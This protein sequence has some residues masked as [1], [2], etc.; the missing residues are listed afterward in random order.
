MVDGPA[1]LDAARL[2]DL[3]ASMLPGHLGIRIASVSDGAVEAALEVRSI[4]LAPN[5]FLHAAAVVAL[6]DTATG[7]GCARSLPERAIGFTTA[8]LKAN[9]LGTATE[10]ELWCTASLLHGGRTTQVWDA[11]VTGDSARTLAVFRCTQ[12]ILW[13]ST[14]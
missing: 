5:G 8:E 9:L 14:G 6:A 12:I 4:H 11:V 7:Y 2:N 13:P 10:G 3:G 1:E